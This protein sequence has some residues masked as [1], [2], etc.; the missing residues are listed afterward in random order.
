MVTNKKLNALNVELGIAILNFEYKPNP[1]T[2]RK[3]ALAR[4]HRDAYYN[5]L[6]K[7]Q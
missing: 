6:T 7:N 4:D 5:T 3:L 2:A 1:N